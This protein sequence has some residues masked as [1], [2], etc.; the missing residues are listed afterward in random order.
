[1]ANNKRP[2]KPYNS[3]KR[4]LHIPMTAAR[5]ALALDLHLSTEALIA[6]PNE[7]TSDKMARILMAMANAINYNSPVRIRDR[8][9]PD[10]VAVKTALEALQAVQERLT[11]LGR[12]G[13]SGD[14][15][16]A[17]RA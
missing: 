4:R 2:R 11:R 6:D 9:D 14:E 17:L 5:H 3:E 10:G 1:M 12:Y 16:N 15:I 7:H 8:T 13:L